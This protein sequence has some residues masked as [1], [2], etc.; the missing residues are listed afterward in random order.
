MMS[1]LAIVFIPFL[2]LLVAVF[3]GCISMQETYEIPEVESYDVNNSAE[4]YPNVPEDQI[5][6][7]AS[8]KFAPKDYVILAKLK[9]TD[10][11]DWITQDKLMEEFKKKASSLGANAVIVL[12]LNPQSHGG[13]KVF[14]REENNTN[15]NYMNQPIYDSGTTLEIPFS[16]QNPKDDKFKGDALAVWATP[17]SS[18]N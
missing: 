16:T 15:P 10:E 7:Y 8:E 12:D 17:L 5:I 3:S 1:R 9:S 6:V 14:S 11:G 4:K 2:L 18:Q 13:E